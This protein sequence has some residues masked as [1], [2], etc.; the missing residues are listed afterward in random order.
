MDISDPPNDYVDGL[1]VGKADYCT[2]I[3]SAAAGAFEPV[4]V[5]L[6]RRSTNRRS[7]DACTIDRGSWSSDECH[8]PI[9]RLAQSKFCSDDPAN[10]RLFL[11]SYLAMPHLAEP[12]A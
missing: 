10:G 9:C 3:D 8:F 4:R 11:M 12:I 7:G 1:S 2:P 6:P 5:E